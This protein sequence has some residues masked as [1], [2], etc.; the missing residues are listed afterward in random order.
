M[1]TKN[2]LIG[3]ISA[4]PNEIEY[5]ARILQPPVDIR[6]IGIRRFFIGYLNNRRVVATLSGVGMTNAAMTTQI[7][8]DK[9]NISSVFFIGVAAILN[10]QY[11]IGDI[12]IADKWAE[13]QYQ[14]LIRS[15]N[16]GQSFIDNNSDFP[17]RF[18]RNNNGKIISLTRPSCVSC[19]SITTGTNNSLVSNYF[20]IPMELQ[21]L[22][23][24]VDPRS[25][26]FPEQFWLPVDSN[27][28]S[29]IRKIIS[30]GYTLNPIY[31]Y[32]PTIYIGANGISSS[33]YVDNNEYGQLLNQQLNADIVDM[34]SAAFMHV[35]ISNKIPAVTIRSMSDYPGRGDTNNFHN[36]VN[37]TSVNNINLVAQIIAHL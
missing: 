8:I 36:V 2:L 19:N 5:L 33:S 32:T 27:L 16:N 3:L 34:E 29:N 15:E 9:F 18:Y 14:K 7:M 22:S 25:A 20:A 1:N 24:G 21:V 6:D 4:L 17:N 12:V 35:C 37:I 26:N 10:P 13:Y 23:I 31:S 30:A 28:L 11:K